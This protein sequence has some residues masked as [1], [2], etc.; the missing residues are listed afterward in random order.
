VI[1]LAR[2]QE[3]NEKMREERKKQILEEA[4]RQFAGKG[5]FATKIKDIAEAVGMAQGLIYH[6]YKSKEDIY[7]E[8]IGDA[9]D[10]MSNAVYMLQE[11]PKPPHQ[12]IQMAIERLLETIECSEVFTQTCLLIAQA[13]N[14]TAVPENAKKLIEEKRDIPYQVIA[15]IM[16]EGQK[17][18]TIIKADPSELAVIFWTSINGLALYKATRQN[19]VAI[20]DAR[21]LISLFLEGDT[22]G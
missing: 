5:L 9:L 7:V 2:N 14:S 1:C 18:G 22:H 21:I 10:K 11:L 16:A 8:L 3:Q 6:Y 19:G 17:Q 4:L 13:T 12:K 20:P 15:Q